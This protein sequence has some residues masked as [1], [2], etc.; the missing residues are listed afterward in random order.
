M[1]PKAVPSIYTYQDE[2]S[3][4]DVAI[5]FFDR[6]EWK[7][8]TAS[9][10]AGIASEGGAAGPVKEYNSLQRSIDLPKEVDAGILKKFNGAEYQST[11][12]RYI[13][14]GRVYV[15]LR[16]CRKCQNN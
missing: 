1:S 14:E 16:Y 7:Q 8:R 6:E 3:D 11:I 15:E 4:V 12:E 10:V 9:E 13:A 5:Q 2:E